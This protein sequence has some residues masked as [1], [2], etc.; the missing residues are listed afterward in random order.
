MLKF[1]FFLAVALTIFL[2]TFVK[3]ENWSVEVGAGG[4]NA[5]DP[6]SFSANAEDTVSI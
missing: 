6:S 4:K 1:F 2:V 3:S 5:F